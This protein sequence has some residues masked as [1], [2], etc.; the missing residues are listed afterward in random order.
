MGC[1]KNGLQ[2]IAGS[3]ECH[4]VRIIGIIV[5]S[6]PVGYCT[7]VVLKSK[8]TVALDISHFISDHVCILIGSFGLN[9]K[10]PTQS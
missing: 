5:K 8:S 9:A 2:Y 10:E 1:D 4:D 3:K 6:Q 7:S